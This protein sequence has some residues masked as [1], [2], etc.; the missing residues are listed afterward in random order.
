LPLDDALA[1]SLITFHAL[2]AKER[3]AAGEAYTALDYVLCDELGLPYD[4]ARLRRVWYRL[5]GAAGVRKIQPYT[6]SRHAAGSYLAHAGVSADIIRVARSHRRELH[7]EDL[8]PRSAGGPGR[9][10][11]R[12]SPEDRQGV[13][14][15]QP[16]NRAPP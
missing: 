5:M 4:P 15:Q 9:R 13:N 11:R 7:H 6:A 8:R 12:A 10:A 16:C 1:A 2:Q 3:L 14:V